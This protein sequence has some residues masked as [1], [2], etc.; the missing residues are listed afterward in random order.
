MN[1]GFYK[2]SETDSAT[3]KR[4]LERAQADIA[5]IAE[6]VRPI[7]DAVR[8]Q[9]DTA[10]F[11]FA[12]RFDKAALKSLK[13]TAEEFD[14]ARKSIDPVLKQT[15][16]RC[17]ANVRKFH[18]E[19]MN[20]VE[21]PWMVEIEE[22]VFAGEKIT[23]V[24][25]VGLYVPGGKNLFPSSVYMLAVPA[26]VAK[27]PEII[28]CTPPRSDGSISDVILVAAELSG[29]TDIYKAGGAQA[30]AAMAYGTQSIPKVHKVLG[31]CSPFGA[32]AKQML[33]GLINPGMPA[34]PSEAIILCDDSADPENTILDVLN[35]AEHGPD[36]AGLLV[37]HDRKLAEYVR[38]GLAR[39]IATLPDPQRGYLTENMQSYSGVILTDSLEQSIEVVNL[40]APEH[41]L[42]KVRDPE[43]VITKI[44]NAGEILIG[45]N[46]PSSLGNYGIGTNHVLP[47]G[48]MAHS[49][50][51]T[52]VWDYL[53]RI[54]LA[55]VDAKGLNAL[56]QAVTVMAEY[57]G[58]PAH[59]NVIRKRRIYND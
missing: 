22:G 2:W 48:G 6:K 36:S 57:E 3:K 37:T 24:T 58:F 29:V 19:Q 44:V 42:V 16:E 53:K 5:G 59:A 35:E 1:I 51:C 9:G 25:S 43:S 55:S 52:T 8:D 46:S 12:Q 18:Q 49:Y 15:L 23:P 14:A 28:I 38:D 40:Y 26:I 17:I 45:E 47:T 13:V 32:A 7:L 31:P 20:R 41:V 27:V 10:L 39:E 4:L 54:S 11:D 30:I 33:G 34:G 21:K 56:S 50:S